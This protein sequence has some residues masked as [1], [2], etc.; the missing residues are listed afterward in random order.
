MSRRPITGRATKKLVAEGPWEYEANIKKLFMDKATEVDAVNLFD[1]DRWLYIE[2]R[3]NGYEQDGP[4]QAGDAFV[5]K[6][7]RPQNFQLTGQDNGNIECSLGFLA[8]KMV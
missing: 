3:L 1:C 5:L 2:F 4:L 8:G 7:C 6:E